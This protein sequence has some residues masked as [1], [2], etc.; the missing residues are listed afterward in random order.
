MIDLK[1]SPLGLL[2]AVP[3]SHK[4]IDFVKAPTTKTLIISEAIHTA[5]LEPEVFLDTYAELQKFDARTK[6]GKGKA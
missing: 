2:K 4:Y 3:C 1:Q 6:E 5:V